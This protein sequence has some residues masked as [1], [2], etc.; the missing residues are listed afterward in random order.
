[1][2]GVRPPR[3][4][5]TRRRWPRPLLVAGLVAGFL[6]LA[7]SVTGVVVQIMPRTFSAAQR[8]QIMAWEVGK[9][10]R[11]WPAGQIFP[12]VISYRLSGQAF[13]SSSSLP[14]T[15]QR[16]GIAKQ[17]SCKVAAQRAAAGVL[18]QHGCLAVLRATY[19]DATQTMAVTIGVAVL[20]GS[21]AAQQSARALGDPGH[22]RWG[23]RAVSFRR[24]ATAR[25]GD[26]SQK[27]VWYGVAGPYLVLATVGYADGRP[28]L[29]RGG[30]AYTR[31]ELLG[32]A[33]GAGGRV[34]SDLASPAPVPRCPGSPA[35]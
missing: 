13:R 2:P 24:T 17:A 29:G 1:M 27:L 16:V 33:S 28:W 35:C 8:Q 4:G 9:R 12:Q 15:A 22:P 10:W 18:A 30:D 25:F 19:E 34:A 14:L 3:R 26:R 32:L 31:D 20:P 23:I 6:G 21:S 7:V 5:R 11:T